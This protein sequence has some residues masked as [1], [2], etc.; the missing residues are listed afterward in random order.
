MKNVLITG[1]ANGLGLEMS[2]WFISLKYN[3]FIIDKLPRSELPAIL[4]DKIAGYFQIDLSSRDQIMEFLSEI[5]KEKGFDVLVLNAFPRTFKNFIDFKFKEISD[6]TEIGFVH[7][8]M[9]CN[10]VLQWMEKKN[11][12]RIIMI[13][14]KSSF[15]GYS[16]GSLYCS[17][18]MALIGI[19]DSLSRELKYSGKN[20]T[21]SIIHPDSF[22]TN[23]GKKLKNYKTTIRKI[24]SCLNKILNGQISR[25]Y[26]AMGLKSRLILFLQHINKSL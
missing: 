1:G 6:F 4:K 14:S 13:G 5:K 25:Q 19:F 22:S 20:I 16:K 9:I 24:F 12:G 21:V 17:L 7:Q 26:Y 3:L 11:F 2:Q 23:D 15:Q 10:T 18:K 8:M